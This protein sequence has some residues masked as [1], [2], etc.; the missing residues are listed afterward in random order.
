MTQRHLHNSAPSGLPQL[1]RRG[2]SLQVLR[3]PLCAV[4]VAL[5]L[6]G[7]GAASPNTDKLP[8]PIP[9]PQATPRSGAGPI[10]VTGKAVSNGGIGVP[11]V[12]IGFKLTTATA[13]CSTCGFYSAA[14]DSS[15]VYNADMPPGTYRAVCAAGSGTNCQ[16]TTSTSS[17]AS[18]VLPIVGSGALVNMLVTTGSPSSSPQPPNTAQSSSPVDPGGYVVHGSVKTETGQPI[19]NA[20]V[21]FEDADCAN[22]DFQPHTTTDSSGAYAITLPPGLYTS[23]C[24]PTNCGPEGGDGGPDPFTVPPG[25]TLNFIVCTGN[26]YPQCLT[27]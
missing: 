1:R 8:S 17:A 19:P 4:G 16:I 2:R 7:C 21:T 26:D 27:G 11:N 23:D 3:L 13:A 10:E 12:V 14:T 5:M 24:S 15:G 18:V 9:A 22:C 6:A 20:Y 25:R